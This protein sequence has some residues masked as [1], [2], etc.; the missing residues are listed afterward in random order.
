MNIESSKIINN[1][2]KNINLDEEYDTNL[3]GKELNIT[4]PTKD[5]IH[6][7]INAYSYNP[8]E[9]RRTFNELLNIVDD[10]TQKKYA[11][12]LLLIFSYN[13]IRFLSEN[14]LYALLIKYSSHHFIVEKGWH[15]LV[16][17]YNLIFNDKMY[18]DVGDSNIFEPVLPIEWI[19]EKIKIYQDK[20]REIEIKKILKDKSYKYEKGEIIGAKDKEGRWWM[21]RIIEIFTYNHHSVYYVEFLGWGENF[22][23]FIVDRFRID[24]YNPIKHKYFRPNWKK[25]CITAHDKDKHEQ[26]RQEQDRQEQDRQEQD[27]HDQDRHEQ[28][29]HDQDR[30]EQYKHDQDRQKQDRHEQTKKD[31]LKYVYDIVEQFNDTKD[32]KDTNNDQNTIDTDTKDTKDTKNDQNTIDTDTKDIYMSK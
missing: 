16:Y 4:L 12:K 3:K 11:A 8:E 1:Y 5:N 13:N 25:T 10:S 9:I 26:D 23:E 21:S 30:H 24:R 14:K 29:R 7:Y 28:D 22:N 31:K 17:Y 6:T 2:I 18:N 15:D 19:N 27:R 32:T 20:H